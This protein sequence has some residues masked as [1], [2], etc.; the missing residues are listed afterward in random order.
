MKVTRYSYLDNTI[1]AVSHGVK[2]GPRG[3]TV[4]VERSGLVNLSSNSERGGLQFTWNLLSEG[5]IWIQQFSL[6]LRVNSRADW[7]L[8]F[9]CGNWSCR[10]PNLDWNQL[11]NWK[12]IC[13]ARLFLP[14]T[15][16]KNTTPTT[17]SWSREPWRINPG[18]IC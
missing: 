9:C 2:G 17:K 1:I 10:T 4:I 7:T 15:C 8:L 13:S 3:V 5:K 18:E 16:Y 6:Q 12:E 11:Q 14:K